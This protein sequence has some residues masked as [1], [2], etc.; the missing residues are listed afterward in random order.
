[1]CCTI[2]MGKRSCFH[3]SIA[4]TY[5]LFSMADYLFYQT[6]SIKQQWV[7]KV[8]TF[9]LIFTQT[10]SIVW[11]VYVIRGSIWL[12]DLSMS[13]HKGFQFANIYVGPQNRW[14]IDG[15]PD[16]I[17]CSSLSL[18]ISAINSHK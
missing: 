12:V 17:L 13:T 9:S 5:R 15:F 8:K 7:H 6:H 16:L 10:E 1:M 11:I 4:N 3:V 2:L 14:N 18:M